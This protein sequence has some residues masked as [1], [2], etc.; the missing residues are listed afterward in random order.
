[1][2][3]ESLFLGQLLVEKGIITD[4]QLQEA[5]EEH[6]RTG[7]LLG[8]VLVDFGH[9]TE[10]EIILTLGQELGMEAVDLKEIGEIPQEA[11]QKISPNMAKL[12]EVIPFAI[13]G[14]TLMVAM[15][16]PLNPN[17]LDDLRFMLDVEVKGAISNKRD[18]GDAI[19]KYYGDESESFSDLLE[20]IR[21]EMPSTVVEANANIDITSLK[22]LASEAPVVKLLNLVLIQA[23]NDKASDIHFEPF[24]TEFKI[25]YRIDGVLYEM[26]PPPKHLALAITSRIKVMANLNI[27]ERRLPQDGRIQL[28]ISGRNVDLRIS[29]LPTMFGESVVMRILDRSNVQLDIEALGLAE[30]IMKS[31]E[32]LIERPNGIIIATGPTGCGKTTTLYSCLRRINRIEDK[33]IT[34]EDPVEYDIEGIIQVAINESI[35]LTFARC[36]RSILRQ[37][38]DK[39]MVGE[40]R[41]LETAEIAVQASLTGHLVFSTLHTN[42]AA[43]SITRMIDMG[44]EPFLITSTLQAILAQRLLRTICPKC[45]TEFKPTEEM[46]ME[47]GLTP[48]DIKGKKLYYGKGCDNCNKSGYKGRIGVYELLLVTD[49]I[50]ELIM[51]KAPAVAIKEKASE[52]GMVTLHDDAILKLYDGLTTIEEVAVWTES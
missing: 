50:R 18:I 19:K 14:N 38:P 10:A 27:A 52:L 2:T 39:I 45:K 37:D 1:M 4:E 24:E 9:I 43:G 49:E 7:R 30:D 16:D 28:N 36:L 21:E 29:T 34:T 47:I 32:K 44:A 33:I 31:M 26:V 15:A 17:M 48:E 40:I 13:R 3:S 22:E 41:D 42:D 23:I 6:D 12:Y 25:R 35:G 51:E 46:L 5:K 11:I 8:H 20:E